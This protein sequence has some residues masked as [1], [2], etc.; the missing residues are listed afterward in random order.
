MTEKD[1]TES[2]FREKL[3][4][5]F[6]YGLIAANSTMIGSG[7]INSALQHQPIDWTS[8]PVSTTVGGVAVT[9]AVISSVWGDRPMGVAVANTI[10]F[11]S[12]SGLTYETILEGHNL[13]STGAK[14]TLLGLVGHTAV[15]SYKKAWN[16][17]KEDKIANQNDIVLNSDFSE[18]IDKSLRHAESKS[19]LAQFKENIASVVKEYP[20]AFLGAFGVLTN[21]LLLQGALNADNN[22][23]LAIA[24]GIWTGSCFVQIF[25]KDKPKSAE[26]SWLS[27]QFTRAKEA[28]E[29]AV[30]GDGEHNNH[31]PSS[32]S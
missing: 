20:Y 2:N 31:K 22:P 10:G 6:G 14:L 24:A 32:P 29:I 26:P 5:V 7:I 12:L 25:A 15:R 4:K 9:S 23:A 8:S 13:W 21:G 1:N 30:N 18:Q 19:T 3:G 27:K 11:V 16:E 28:L 17:R